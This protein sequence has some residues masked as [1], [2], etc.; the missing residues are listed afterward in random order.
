VLPAEDNHIPDVHSTKLRQTNNN[1][2]DTIKLLEEQLQDLSSRNNNLN[3]KTRK[4]DSSIWRKEHTPYEFCGSY[5]A[6]GFTAKIPICDGFTCEHNP[7]TEATTCVLHDIM[8]DKEKLKV[9][10]GGEDIS[11]VRNRENRD[12]LPMYSSGVVLVNDENCEVGRVGL[13]SMQ[14][15]YHGKFVKSVTGGKKSQNRECSTVVQKTTLFITRYEYANLY[16][17]YTDLYN[18]F[19]AMKVHA[20]ENYEGLELDPVQVVF[21]DGHSKSHMD[22]LWVKLFRTKPTYVSD[23]PDKTCFKKA[24]LVAPGYTSPLSIFMMGKKSRKLGQCN[25]PPG[26]QFIKNFVQEFKQAFG[27]KPRSGKPTILLGKSYI[28]ITSNISKRD[29]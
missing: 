19:L 11:Q 23:V 22:E 18:L 25:L 16:H 4:Y 6:N 26:N 1:N 7:T 15:K 10:K 9:S 21:L 17:T 29:A 28:I 8:I 2:R 20:D 12:E 3:I 24:V 5:Y 13:D 27:I 14:F